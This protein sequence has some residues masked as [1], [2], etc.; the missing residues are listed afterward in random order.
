MALEVLMHSEVV[1]T[2]LE[3][4]W[5]TLL[6]YGAL[7]LAGWWVLNRMAAEE[8]A[9]RDAMRPPPPE[10]EADARRKAL[11]WETHCQA[12]RARLEEIGGSRDYDA[13]LTPIRAQIAAQN[14]R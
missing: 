6:L 7:F 2:L 14:Q 8:Q 4:S 9:D 10:V 13:Y 11:A 5:G 12:E 1:T 3:A